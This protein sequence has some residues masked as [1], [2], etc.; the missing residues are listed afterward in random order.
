MKKHG[1]ISSTWSSCRPN[2]ILHALLDF[3]LIYWRYKLLLQ[4][5]DMISKILHSAREK[6]FHEVYT[7]LPLLKYYKQKFQILRKFVINIYHQYLYDKLLLRKLVSC[8]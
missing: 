3:T 2:A 4:C 6:G 1:K 7:A 8:I 5:Y